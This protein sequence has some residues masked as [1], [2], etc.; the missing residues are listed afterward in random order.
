LYLDEPNGIAWIGIPLKKHNPFEMT[1]ILDSMK[2]HL[3]LWYKKSENK[4][5][6]VPGLMNGIHKSYNQ[7][8]K[9]IGR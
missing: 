5:V 3:Y 9:M 4:S 2:T 8:K 1:L 6:I 7:I